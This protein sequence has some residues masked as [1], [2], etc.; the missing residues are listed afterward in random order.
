MMVNN[1]TEN[2]LRTVVTANYIHIVDICFRM[3][4]HSL[5]LGPI[6]LFHHNQSTMIFQGNRSL[7]GPE[8]VAR[9]PSESLAFD[10]ETFS[11]QYLLID[12]GS[13]KIIRI[14]CKSIFA[15]KE[16]EVIGLQMSF[17]T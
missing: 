2:E 3:F 4:P 1:G 15:E 8:K 14:V 13:S 11:L 5:P 6:P 7:Q 12:L 17:H 9:K 10:E 16:I